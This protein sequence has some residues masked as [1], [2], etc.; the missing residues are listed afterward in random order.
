MSYKQKYV[1]CGECQAALIF[2]WGDTV[3][4]YVRMADGKD[5][6]RE[7]IPE[8]GGIRV[9][10]ITEDHQV[11]HA[12][13]QC[14]L[15]KNAFQCA[16][17]ADRFEKGGEDEYSHIDP[18]WPDVPPS[19]YCHQDCWHEATYG[20]DEDPQYDHPGETPDLWDTHPEQMRLRQ[21]VM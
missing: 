11:I 7:I 8:T 10:S 5:Y 18:N 1:F 4:R 19:Q 20:R 6:K 16:G 12:D 2:L 14:K 9:Q 17:C 3:Y 21:E 13:P 15:L